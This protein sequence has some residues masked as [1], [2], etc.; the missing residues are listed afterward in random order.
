MWM[1]NIKQIT[2]VVIIM[3]CTW[4]WIQFISKYGRYYPL[5]QEREPN[6]HKMPSETQ[7]V[8]HMPFFILL[9]GTTLM[10]V[11]FGIVAL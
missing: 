8:D 10:I 5:Y 3:T 6:S 11:G 2:K 4:L 1:I 7:L 9:L